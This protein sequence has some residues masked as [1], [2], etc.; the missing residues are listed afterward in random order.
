MDLDDDVLV[1]SSSSDEFEGAGD[2][3]ASPLMQLISLQ[4]FDG[5]YTLSEKFAVI[6]GKSLEEI[7]GGASKANLQEQVFTTAL[8]ISFYVTK[9]SGEK[10]VWELIVNKARK[11]LGKSLQPE[12]VTAAVA[13]ASAFLRA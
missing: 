11:W 10:D 12:Q 4:S 3:T 13:A 8:A 2:T 1:L 9:M 5:S 7:K 6:V